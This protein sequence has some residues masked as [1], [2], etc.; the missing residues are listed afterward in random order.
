MAIIKAKKRMLGNIRFVGELYKLPKMLQDK[1]MH[2]CIQKLLGVTNKDAEGVLL[3]DSTHMPVLKEVSPISASDEENMEALV[4]LLATIGR[5]LEEDAV[6]A[7][8]ASLVRKYLE[9][10]FAV[11]ED[12][13]LPSRMRFMVQDLLEMRHNGYMPRRREDKQMTQEEIRRLMAYEASGKGKGE[14]KGKGGPPPQLMRHEGKGEGKGDVRMGRGLGPSGPTGAPKVVM[15]RGA[16][17]PRSPEEIK[18]SAE[19]LVSRPLK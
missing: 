1:I 7:Y 14:G 9:R 8:K 13:A 17:P 6:D 2:D 12:R 18:K 4:K 15:Q 10:L 19:A 5:K 3:M 11:T 16:A